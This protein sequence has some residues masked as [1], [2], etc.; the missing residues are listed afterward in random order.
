MIELLNVVAPIAFAI[1]IVGVGLR[2]WRFA[3]ALMT[4]R[5]FRGVSP[6]F[7]SPPPRM[8]VFPALYAVLFG[9]FN[10]FYKRSNPVW[11]RGY[12]L[13]HVAIITEVTGY[14]ISA[15]IVFA[16]I[17]LGRPVPDV[18]LKLAESF[19]YSPANLL[20]IIFGNGK[21]LQANFLFGDFGPYFI[22]ITW[23]AVIFAVIGNLH[24][25][26]ALVR[27]WSGAVVGDIDRASQGIRTPGR[28][29]WDR[30]AIRS[31]IFC[32]IWTELLS[33]LN[34]VPDTI[35][36]HALLGMALFTLLPFTYLFHMA[37]NFLAIFYAV[38]RRMERTIA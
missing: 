20:A 1:L 24:L 25:M 34:I 16:N 13:Y 8:G 7:E 38:R 26:V 35:Y 31:I 4:K 22:G 32:I 21:A 19:N 14:T 33:R 15:F 29:A 30:I 18:S 6:T 12:L 10:H 5:R 2:F 3:W 23:V 9:P 17:L 36:L 37:Y 27:K 11:G 28:Y